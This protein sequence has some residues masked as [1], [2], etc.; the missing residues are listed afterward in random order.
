MWSDNEFRIEN[1]FGC[2][3]FYNFNK[4]TIHFKQNTYGIKRHKI[5]IAYQKR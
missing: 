1:Y 5:N 4:L 3:V 2:N